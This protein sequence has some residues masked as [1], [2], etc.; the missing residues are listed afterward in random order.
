MSKRDWTLFLWAQ[1]G[2]LR[3]RLINGYFLVDYGIVWEIIQN[4]LPRLRQKLEQI[5]QEL[6]G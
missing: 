6:S 2:D 1:I 3:N 5:A 4:E